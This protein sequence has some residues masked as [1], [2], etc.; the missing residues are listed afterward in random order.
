VYNRITLYFTAASDRC[1]IVPSSDACS[2]H[3]QLII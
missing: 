2:E 3:N 1:A